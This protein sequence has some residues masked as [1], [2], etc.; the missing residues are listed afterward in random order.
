VGLVLLG[1]AGFASTAKDAPRVEQ[2]TP[3]GTAREVRQVA[4]RFSAPMVAW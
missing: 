4:V 1:T 3:T 2:F